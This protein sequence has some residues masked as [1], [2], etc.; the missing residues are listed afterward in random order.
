MGA[1]LFILVLVS[2]SWI[3]E[4]DLRLCSKHRRLV[5]WTNPPG[6]YEDDDGDDDDDDGMNDDDI[7]DDN[8]DDLDSPQGYLPHW[9]Q[10]ACAHDRVVWNDIL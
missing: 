1:A 8:Y 3:Q 7:N 10:G 5:V 9:V 4:K 6:N 2:K